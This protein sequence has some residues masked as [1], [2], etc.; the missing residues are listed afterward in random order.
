MKKQTKQ[1]TEYIFDER[2]AKILKVCLD[3]CWHRLTQ[4]ESGIEG[5]VS[6]KEID[7]LRK[8]LK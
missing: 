5:M 6:R 3:Y 2:E 4:H 7:R 8:E 1:I